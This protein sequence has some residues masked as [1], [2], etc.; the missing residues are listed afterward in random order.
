MK[1]LSVL[2]LFLSVIFLS[3]QRS[4]NVPQQTQTNLKHIQVKII[5]MT[6]EIGCARIIE[7]KISKLSGVKFSKVDFAKSIG[8]FSFDPKITST[9][10]IITKINGIGGGNLYKVIDYKEVKKF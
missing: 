7:S 3:F 4:G 10:K 8:Q 1:K 6:C 9:E 5:G 2:I